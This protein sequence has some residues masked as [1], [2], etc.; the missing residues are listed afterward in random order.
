MQNAHRLFVHLASPDD[1][2]KTNLIKQD[3]RWAHSMDIAI[4]T[5]VLAM[6]CGLDAESAQT[7]LAGFLRSLPGEGEPE[8]LHPDA[9][10]RY[11][12]RVLPADIPW[13]AR[14]VCDFIL[15]QAHRG[16]ALQFDL[17]RW[18]GSRFKAVP[19]GLPR[20]RNKTPNA[21]NYTPHGIS[22]YRSFQG[23]LRMGKLFE[24][25]TVLEMSHDKWRHR[26]TE[27]RPIEL[28]ETNGEYWLHTRLAEMD[29]VWRFLEVLLKE[30]LEQ[31]QRPNDPEKLAEILGLVAQI[32]WWFSHAMP[33]RR[34]SAA[35]G[36]MLT[37]AILQFHQISTPC[38]RVGIGPDLEAFCRSI[39]DYVRAYPSMF[40]APPRF[41]NSSLRD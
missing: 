25:P 1:P 33:Y 6:R 3:M 13:G 24:L 9:H 23:R 12:G 41:I 15:A 18:K 37:K 4:A 31:E 8:S 22:A 36:D 21:R 35:I 16:Y 38:W 34:G 32:H 29:L 40:V 10:A 11:S 30:V 7:R 19:I 14:D 27:A 26:P 20:T 17:D 39:E 2:D 28:T 5:A